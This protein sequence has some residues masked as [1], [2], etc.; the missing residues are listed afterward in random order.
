[1]RDYLNWAYFWQLVQAYSIFVLPSFH[2]RWDA[3]AIECSWTDLCQRLFVSKD[4]RDKWWSIIHDNY[5]SNGRHYHTLKHIQFMLDC[6][7]IFQKELKC[8]EEVLLAIYF[9][10]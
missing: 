6:C 10:E 2:V 9:H 1:M 8:V 5:Q 7:E 3:A 4:L